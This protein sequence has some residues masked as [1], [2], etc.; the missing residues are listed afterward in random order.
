MTGHKSSQMSI[1]MIGYVYISDG[2]YDISLMGYKSWWGFCVAPPHK[3]AITSS[4]WG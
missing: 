1:S 3:Q 2:V 4:I